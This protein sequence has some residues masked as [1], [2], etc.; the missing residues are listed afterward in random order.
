MFSLR[1]IRFS[2]GS[3]GSSHIYMW[4]KLET[5]MFCR[6]ERELLLFMFMRPSNELVTCP[7]LTLPF[8]YESLDRLQHTAVILSLEERYYSFEQACGGEKKGMRSF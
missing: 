3:I 8:P 1:V 6:C 7:G 4:S 2:V 5:Q